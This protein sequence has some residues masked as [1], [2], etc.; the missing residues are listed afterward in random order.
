MFKPLQAIQVN[1]PIVFNVTVFPPVLGPVIS[2]VEKYVPI[3]TLIGTT[4]FLSIKGCLASIK[5]ISL[6]L[7]ISGVIPSIDWENLAFA[8][9]KSNFPI[10]STSEF[11][12]SICGKKSKK[13]V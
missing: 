2:N 9:I 13:V 3:L 4:L 1:K 12:L 5:F 7:F 8:K 10:N 11:N 6:L